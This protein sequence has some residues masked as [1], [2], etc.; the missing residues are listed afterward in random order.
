MNTAV[1]LACNEEKPVVSNRDPD[2]TIKLAIRRVRRA[3][4]LGR[5]GDCADVALGRDLSY[6]VVSRV[7][8]KKIALIV[9]CYAARSIKHRCLR[10]A[11][12]EPRHAR[13]RRLC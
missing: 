8:D 7:C 6:R 5:P 2:G 4:V 9:N 12:D 11:V 10:R 3:R 1:A 13:A